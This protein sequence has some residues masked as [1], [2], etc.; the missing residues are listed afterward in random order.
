MQNHCENYTDA[1][2]GHCY[3]FNSGKNI[4]NE[5][6]PIKRSINGLSEGFWLNFYFNSTFELKIFTMKHVQTFIV[7]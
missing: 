7:L 4:S 3:K 5:S 6:I 2:Y 1:I